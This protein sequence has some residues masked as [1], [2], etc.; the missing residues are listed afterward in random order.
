MTGNR[1]ELA[2]DPRVLEVARCA[3]VILSGPERGRE[4]TIE[5]ELFRIGKSRDNE[6]VLADETVSRT[7]CEITRGE[8]GFLL[9][10]LGSTNGTLLDGAEIKEAWLK[11]G[12]VITV[13]KVE[14]KVRPF[15]ERIEILPSDATT[16][17]EVVGSSL[18]M[19]QVFGLLERLGP[20]DATVLIGGETGTGKDVLARSIHARSPRASEPFIVVDCGAVV[21]SLIE[22]ELFGHEKGAFTGATS[23]RQGA[24]ELAD[25]GTLF[26][27]EIGE[28]P[29]DLQP[30]LLRA[31]EQRQ[32]RRVGGNESHQVD[33]RVIAAS[34]RNLKMEVERGKFREDLYFR[35]AVVPVE[36]PP[37]RERREDVKILV[38]T[39]LARIAASDPSGTTPTR[40]SEEAMRALEAHDWPGN[41][42]EL[43][44][45][46]ERA[47]YL[48]RAAGYDEVQLGMV[49]F[50][51]APASPDEA[52]SGP[53]MPAFDPDKSYRDTKAEWEASFEKQYVA[54]LLERTEGNISAA[55]RAADMDRK[56]LYK[57]A[58]RHG[59]HPKR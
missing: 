46:L 22:S 9:R 5:G 31:L 13:G 15:A 6:L 21:G 52:S 29:L 12:A 23:R 36:L 11:P 59:L 54:W 24:F 51:G 50:A 26:L 16:Y 58:R 28:L 57:L 39:L 55:A 40:V 2:G 34:K 42:R 7:H 17:G 32:F 1:T 48:S 43:R 3:L 10:D 4:Q 35:L 38:E 53:S 33:I 20:T 19:R 8:K 47:A 41:V 37:L 30:K 14:L 45:V 56:Y 18:A 27:D 25:G 49:P 44:N